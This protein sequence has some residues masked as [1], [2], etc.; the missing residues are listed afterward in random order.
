MPDL[1]DRQAVIGPFAFIESYPI[2]AG[3]CRDQPVNLFAMRL[4]GCQEGH[5]A[6]LGFLPF[7]RPSGHRR[8]G[9]AGV[10]VG[11]TIHEAAIAEEEG[12]GHVPRDGVVCAR[13]QALWTRRQTLLMCRSF[14]QGESGLEPVPKEQ[15]PR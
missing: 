10:T 2:G 13:M 8:A 1:G 3:N 5:A 6:Q 4:D 9:R 7:T 15:P 12:I 11:G 14:T